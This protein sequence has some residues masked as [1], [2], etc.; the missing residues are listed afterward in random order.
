M[1]R[2]KGSKREVKT[3][4]IYEAA[5][6]AIE[7]FV[8]QK[9]GR[10]DGFG[11]V[12]FLAVRSDEIRFVQVTSNSAHSVTDAAE[13]VEEHAPDNLR[14]DV[15]VWYDRAGARLLD[16]SVDHPRNFETLVD[17]RDSDCLM[18]EELEEFL[19]TGD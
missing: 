8:S 11:W 1:S 17:E 3:R 13:W 14:A 7:K 10:T 4:E 6:Y 5:G 12:D 18:G 15:V 19:G 2:R 16:C 9:Y